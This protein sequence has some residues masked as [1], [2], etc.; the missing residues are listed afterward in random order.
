MGRTKLAPAKPK[1]AWAYQC[2]ECRIGRENLSQPGQKQPSLVF[3]KLTSAA[4]EECSASRE[5]F[6]SFEP[7]F[8]QTTLGQHQPSLISSNYFRLSRVLFI[9]FRPRCRYSFPLKLTVFKWGRDGNFDVQ[10]D[11]PCVCVWGWT[12]RSLSMFIFNHSRYLV[13]ISTNRS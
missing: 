8:H 3:V 12:L 11:F 9:S 5:L 13:R 2:A 7:R 4:A 10:G 6:T 1:F